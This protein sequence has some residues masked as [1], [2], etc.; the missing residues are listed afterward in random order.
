MENIMI[1]IKGLEIEELFEKDL[2]SVEDLLGE[3]RDLKYRIHCLEEEI[4][5]LKE[6]KR[7]NMTDDSKYFGILESD[8]Y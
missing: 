3:L 1:N 6:W 5:D 4:E 2:V 8:F 7:Q